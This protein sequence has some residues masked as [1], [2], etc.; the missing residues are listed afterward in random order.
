MEKSTQQNLTLQPLVVRAWGG[1][2]NGRENKCRL[3]VIAG[4]YS[5]R[6]GMGGEIGGGGKFGM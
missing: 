5:T 4:I 2:G 6:I 1:G 3:Y